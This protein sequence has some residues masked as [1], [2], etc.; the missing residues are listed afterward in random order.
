MEAR[1]PI[2]PK[3][4][5]ML[6]RTPEQAR[7]Q[8]QAWRLAY[9]PASSRPGND[10]DNPTITFYILALRNQAFRM[11]MFSSLYGVNGFEHERDYYMG[12]ADMLIA[13]L[14]DEYKPE[15]PLQ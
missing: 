15:A 7:P 5:K 10:P 6:N 11:Q 13:L 8:K 2:G 9:T 1:D 3:I 4:D 12:A 14:P